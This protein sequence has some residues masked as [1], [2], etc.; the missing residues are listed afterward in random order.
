MYLYDITT[1]TSRGGVLFWPVISPLLVRNVRFD[2]RCYHGFNMY[3]QP[4]ISRG[5]GQQLVCSSIDALSLCHQPLSR[6]FVL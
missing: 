2:S 4:C 6:E 1:L 5:T 3:V